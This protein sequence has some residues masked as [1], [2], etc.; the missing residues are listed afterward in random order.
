M[1]RIPPHIAHMW[2]AMWI[3]AAVAMFADVRPLVTLGAGCV[4]GVLCLLVASVGRVQ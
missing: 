2:I 3:L 1:R 4:A